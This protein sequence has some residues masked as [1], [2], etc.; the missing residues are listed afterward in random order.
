MTNEELMQKAID[1]SGLVIGD[2]VRVDKVAPHHVGVTCYTGKIVKFEKLIEMVGVV[3]E[4]EDNPFSFSPVCFF[5][6]DVI[7]VDK[8]AKL[9]AK[10]AEVEKVRNDPW[11][12]FQVLCHDGWET[13]TE[14]PS[15]SQIG[16]YRHKSEMV[17]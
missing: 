16:T 6:E 14:K 13:C 3:L 1:D 17:K 10:Y 9:K 2:I 5:I 15:F 12:E 4:L 11:V 7:K 8:F